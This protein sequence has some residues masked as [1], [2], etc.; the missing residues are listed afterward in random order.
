MEQSIGGKMKNMFRRYW[1]YFVM[2]VV[3]IM[4]IIVIAVSISIRNSNQVENEDEAKKIGT[5]YQISKDEFDY[6][7]ISNKTY[8]VD[9][10]F[11]EDN[12]LK[13]A[14]I[15]FDLYESGDCKVYISQD[16]YPYYYSNSN[17]TQCTYS[18]QDSNISISST[19]LT[20]TTENIGITVPNYI[21]V[22]DY[23]TTETTEE[24]NV[25]GTILD[26][27]RFM[28]IENMKYVI[29]EAER[30]AENDITT[31]LFDVQSQTVYD[32]SGKILFTLDGTDYFYD[33]EENLNIDPSQYE[34]VTKPM[35]EVREEINS[36]AQE[37]ADNIPEDT[38]EEN[39]PKEEYIKEINFDEFTQ[40]FYDSN[41]SILYIT[42]PDNCLYCTYFEEELTKVVN[43]YGVYAYHLNYGDLTRTEEEE[44]RSMFESSSNY[45]FYGFPVFLKIGNGKV[46]SMN[47]GYIQ[48][49]RIINLL[50]EYGFLK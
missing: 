21:D 31:F 7:L 22:P 45:V 4:I 24:L 49:E 42:I 2:F 17:S 26:N 44:L 3:A 35:D 25:S 37:N 33:E 41:Y 11:T 14:H 36:Q 29:E 30:C 15:T 8:L 43:N 34:I 39:L 1:H 10:M 38:S 47:D 12:N 27:G 28:Q 23:I 40:L 50:Y 32:P 5:L 19:L 16:S 18:M 13:N 20:E 9:Y 46:Y 48:E 6:N